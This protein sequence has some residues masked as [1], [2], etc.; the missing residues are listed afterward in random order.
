MKYSCECID[1]AFLLL[2]GCGFGF[3]LFYRLSFGLFL[4]EYFCQ[5]LLGSGV[6]LHLG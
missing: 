2:L 5:A 4:F 1:E 6:V 3:E